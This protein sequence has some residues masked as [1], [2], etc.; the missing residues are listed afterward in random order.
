MPSAAT[1][2]PRPPLDSTAEPFAKAR[3]W[4]EH[5]GSANCAALKSATVGAGSRSPGSRTTSAE[6]RDG[7]KGDT[8]GVGEG[9]GGKANTDGTGECV[10]DGEGA[11]E[12]A[13]D[14]AELT[15]EIA[16]S[17]ATGWRERASSAGTAACSAVMSYSE[18]WTIE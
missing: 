4:D 5:T 12:G 17:S 3:M 8:G 9:A 15:T 7:E 2:T 18:S 6:E 1:K 11:D 16:V 13:N 14:G 10:D